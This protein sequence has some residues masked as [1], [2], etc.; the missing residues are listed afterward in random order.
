MPP[1]LRPRPQGQAGPAR[2]PHRH[3]TREPSLCPPCPGSSLARQL[4]RCKADV[5][6]PAVKVDPPCL[7]LGSAQPASTAP[8][9]LQE[10]PDPG[11]GGGAGAGRLPACPPTPNSRADRKWKQK[12]KTSRA[13]S[14]AAEKKVPPGPPAPKAAPKAAP[15]AP[16]PPCRAGSPSPAPRQHQRGPSPPRASTAPRARRDR[17]RSASEEGALGPR[18]PRCAAPQGPEGDLPPGRGAEEGPRA[19]APS[20]RGPFR[21]GGPDEL[22]GA[23][24]APPPAPS[25]VVPGTAAGDAAPGHARPPVPGTE[26]SEPRAPYPGAPPGRG[27]GPRHAEV[28]AARGFGGPGRPPPAPGAHRWLRNSAAA[29]APRGA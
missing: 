29:R 24:Q 20:P 13:A 22:M 21:G 11:G 14:P 8:R 5:P 7:N 9:A 6:G 23:G 27:A 26:R 25:R 1:P 28:P 12:A 15:S 18:E 17:K 4:S 2:W 3:P 16:T 10:G 19:C